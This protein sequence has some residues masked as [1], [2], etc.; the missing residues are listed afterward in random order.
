MG[1]D[2]AADGDG[3][4]GSCIGGADGVFAGG[5]AVVAG[6]AIGAGCSHVGRVSPG[7]IVGCA[8]ATGAAVASCPGALMGWPQNGQDATVGSGSCR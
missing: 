1:A 8:A 7:S 6:G 2:G 5:G 3:C 4:T